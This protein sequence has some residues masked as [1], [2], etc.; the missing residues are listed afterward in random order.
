MQNNEGRKTE[1]AYWDAA[2]QLPVKGRLPSRLNVSVLNLTR[3]LERHVR[4]GSRYLEIG[5]APGKMLAW[6]ASKLKAEAAGLDYSEPGIAQC[7]ALFDALELKVDLYQDDLFSHH[8]PSASFDIVTSFGVIEHFD[9]VRPVVQR[10]IDLVKQGGAA[11]IAIPNYGGVYGSLQRWCDAPNL[12]L[13]NLEIM[14]TYS[15]AALVDS[16]D[17]ESACAYPF[18]NISPWLIDFDKRLPRLVTNLVS[19]GVNAIGLLQPLT[20]KA[21]APM[22]VLEIRKG[23]AA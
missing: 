13:H 23:P 8:L 18:G 6:V 1:Q 7:R 4:P 9:N 16:P 20:V 10:H 5:C 3:L 22:L 2:S 11:L 12:A 19:F 15:L 21:L 17:V 14:D